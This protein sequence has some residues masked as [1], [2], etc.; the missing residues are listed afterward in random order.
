M[1]RLL[2][3]FACVL[4]CISVWAETNLLSATA[5]LL[6]EKS[7]FD[8]TTGLKQYEKMPK[9]SGKLNSLGG[10]V[11]TILINRWASEL[12]E[13]YPEVE[14]NIQGGG[15]LDGFA[16][17]LAGETDI[18]PMSRPL[19]ANDRAQFKAKFGYE[20]AVIVVAPV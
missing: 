18:V 20:P 13:L 8:L 11:T 12:A 14:F 7:V 6:D 3:G 19:S 17:L 9:L 15:S 4:T 10:G 2:A 5:L 1:T 16:K